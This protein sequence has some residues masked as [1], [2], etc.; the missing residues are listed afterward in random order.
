[1]QSRAP[2]DTVHASL[3]EALA[4]ILDERTPPDSLMHP[5]PTTYSR[6]ETLRS[7]RSITRQF[8]RPI[9]KDRS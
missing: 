7:I 4:R 3:H 2:P 9:P 8:T 5:F 1:M 6:K